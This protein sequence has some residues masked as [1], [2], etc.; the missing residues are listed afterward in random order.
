MMTTDIAPEEEGTFLELA[1]QGMFNLNWED[2]VGVFTLT[3]LGN[4]LLMQTLKEVGTVPDDPIA[5][6]AN[7]E[8]WKERALGA[9]ARVSEVEHNLLNLS[10]GVLDDSYR[11]AKRPVHDHDYDPSCLEVAHGDYLV[12]ECL[13]KKGTL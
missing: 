11:F 7:A 5:L 4:N 10:T 1:S 2:G 13:K 12:G 6:Q 8:M 9:E 3:A